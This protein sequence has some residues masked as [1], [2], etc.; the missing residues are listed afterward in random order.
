MKVAEVYGKRHDHVIEK[1]KGLNCSKEFNR[2]NFR[3]VEYIDKK[4]GLRH[5]SIF[6][7]GGF[8]LVEYRSLD[9]LMK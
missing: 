6:N 5:S 3:G 1:I 9:H 4:G 7:Q 8:S 2:L